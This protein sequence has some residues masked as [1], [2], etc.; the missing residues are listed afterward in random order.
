MR[1]LMAEDYAVDAVTMVKA[2][3]LA[4]PLGGMLWYNDRAT[5]YILLFPVQSH[6]SDFW[7]SCHKLSK[8]LFLSD[9]WRRIGAAGGIF[10]AVLGAVPFVVST[11]T[12]KPHVASLDH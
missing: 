12:G 1:R 9:E 3:A 8:F 10:V 5:P 4:C 7:L 2:L 11:E 6:G